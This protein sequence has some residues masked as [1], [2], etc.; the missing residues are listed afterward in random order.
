MNSQQIPTTQPEVVRPLAGH[1]EADQIPDPE[2]FQTAQVVPVITAHLT[3]D[4][5]TSSVAPLLPVL[6]EKLSLSLTQA[7]LLTTFMQLPGIFNPFIGYIADKVSFRYFVI[8]APAVTG[9]IISSIGFAQNYATLAILLF[10]AGIS[11]AAFHA[12]APAFVGKVSGRRLGLGMSL[13]MAAGELA[14]AIGPLLAVWAVTT[15]TLDGFWRLAVLGWLASFFLYLRLRN[16]SASVE[17]PGSLRAIMPALPGL[18][19]PIALF[20]LVRYPLM[21][22]LTT[23]LPILM[24]TRGASLW[25][26]GASLSVLMV[27]GVA[28]V[29]LIGPASDRWGRKAVLIVVTIATTGLALLFLKAS[30]WWTLVILIGL[31]F[32][33]MSTNPIMMAIVQERF[34]NNRAM[35]NGIY[36]MVSF[37]LRP[38]G[39]VAV[40]LMGDSIGLERAMFWGA[41]ISLGAIPAI[42][43]LQNKA[44]QT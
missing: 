25:I 12:P 27:S 13:F 21:E 10:C 15:W 26:A 29:L 35:A 38:I 43:A 36:M 40:G 20:S 16:F 9:T 34:P 37:V 5:Y 1:F 7:G 2:A 14:Y 19:L 11:T 42:L 32:F 28:G 44:P 4:I 31:G 24:K 18:Y 6:I 23:Y 41:L 22:S 8:L 3:H 30:G 39:T 17:K 33:S